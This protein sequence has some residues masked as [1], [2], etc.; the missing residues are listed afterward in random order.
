MLYNLTWSCTMP[1]G[2]AKMSSFHS[3]GTCCST[4]DWASLYHL[5]VL[6]RA[7]RLQPPF[8]PIHF[9]NLIAFFLLSRY[10]L[11]CSTKAEAAPPSQLLLEQPR[12]RVVAQ[13]LP[14]RHLPFRDEGERRSCQ[15]PHEMLGRGRSLAETLCKS[16]P[17]WLDLPN[18]GHALRRPRCTYTYNFAANFCKWNL[19]KKD[20]ERFRISY[21][22]KLICL[23][24]SWSYFLVGF[25]V[26]NL[27]LIS[28]NFY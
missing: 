16:L 7:F 23:L 22:A 2:M 20:A 19:G 21:C 12:R 28:L 18:T 11:N 5:L 10:T 9:N 14:T 13:R 17:C 15:S 25:S 26:F 4:F 3:H 8:Y 24:N 27:S 6:S 1:T